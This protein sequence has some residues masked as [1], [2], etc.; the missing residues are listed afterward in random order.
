[1]IRISKKFSLKLLVVLTAVFII[2]PA[3]SP[4]RVFAANSSYE[5]RDAEFNISFTE[6]GDAVITEK[7]DV[8]FISGS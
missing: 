5:V 4:M 2:T 6:D 3:F 8:E 7:W 1:M